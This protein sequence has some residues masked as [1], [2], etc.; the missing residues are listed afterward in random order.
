MVAI[1]RAK[2]LFIFTHTHTHI[3]TMYLKTSE[4]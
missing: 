1:T 2:L 3:Y 4:Q